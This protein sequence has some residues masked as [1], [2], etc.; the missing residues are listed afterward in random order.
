MKL[1]VASLGSVFCLLLL[2]CGD[3][4]GG[5]PGTADSGQQ[6]G[7]TYYKDV[8]P[9]M[10]AKCA[11][12][13]YDGGVA[14]FSLTTY[15]EVEPRAGVAMLAVRDGLMPPW[16]AN[17]DCN[18][19]TGDFSLSDAQKQTIIDWVQQGALEGDPADEG[20]ALP[21]NRL[22][23]SRVDKT[24]TMAQ[25]Y[26][27]QQSPDDYRCFLIP[28]PEEYTTTKYVTGFRAVPGN[29]E[30]VHHVIAYLATPAQVATYQQLDTDEAG[31]GYTCF[32]GSGGPSQEWLGGWAPGNLGSDFP[33]GTG[34]AVE[35]GSMIVMQV[36]YNTLKVGAQSDTTS[37]ELKIDDSV[38]KLGRVQPWTNVSW[39]N[40]QAMEIPAGDSDVM[41]SFEFDM[42]FVTGGQP[43][44]IYSTNLHMHTLGKSGIVKINRADGSEDC[45][46]QIDNYDFDWQDS[47]GFKNPVTFNPGDSMYLE[48]HWDNSPENQPM[49]NGEPRIPVTQFWGEGTTDEMCLTTFYIAY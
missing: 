44:T 20:P 11:T 7:L 1:K 17:K 39:V 6:T 24:V 37:L 42:T 49:V 18:D 47:Y 22:T 9:I 31:P 13:H 5:E 43:F 46:L 34:I 29:E 19:Y 2:A 25:A 45:M 14:P 33:P 23:M 32:G 30:V 4:G 35:P 27:P 8:K 15:D 41:H 26:T 12:C 48:C 28:W 16:K 3:D 38:E 36:H 21:D 10:D 40:S